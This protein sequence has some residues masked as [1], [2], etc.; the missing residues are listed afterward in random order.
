MN[1]KMVGNGRN[2][3]KIY[4]LENGWKCFEHFGICVKVTCF[5]N[6]M[7]CFERIGNLRCI[8]CFENWLQ[9]WDSEMF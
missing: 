4:E 8:E 3:L 6:F 5:G 1:L 9:M 2:G 7:D